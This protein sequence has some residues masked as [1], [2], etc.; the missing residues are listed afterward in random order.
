MITIR[1]VD[2]PRDYR[3]FFNFP[4]TLYRND[5]NWVPP[6]LSS[7]REILEAKHNPAW[8]YLEGDYF[9]A[10]RG[11]ELVGT[12]AAFVNKRHNE[13]HGEQVGWFGA[14]ETI[15]DEGV[16]HS[17]IN[18]AADWVRAKGLPILR[19][20]QTLT[21]HELVGCLVDGFIPPA[22]LMPY[23]PPYYPHL[24]ESAG[25]QKVTDMYS[26][27]L[28]QD[29]ARANGLYDRLARISQSIM[30]RNKITVEVADPKNLKAAFANIKEIYNTAW[31]KNWGFVPLTPRELDAIVDGLGMV[32]DARMLY[33]GYVEGQLAGFILAVPDLNMAIKH[34]YPRPGEWE[35]F[36]LLKVLWH[37][38]VR[39]K[40][41]TVRVPLMGV[42]AEHRSRGVDA[43]LY[44]H[45]LQA[46]TNCGYHKSD[47]GW[48]LEKNETMV[49]I[50]QNFGSRIYKTHR[51]YE[52]AV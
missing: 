29:E 12:V 36:T 11:D 17:L 47:S 37:W 21:T 24:I 27:Y 9:C 50:A 20:P 30:K 1:K 26:F 28:D 52:K 46:I 44:S 42:K 2:N 23:N 49:S 31:D 32:V 22:L 41:D 6:L 35:L 48:I 10:W 34:A 5:P 33:F 15:N 18:T 3:A 25:L 38:K 13:F 14:F 7:R 4:W 43:V 51:L 45:I 39:S 8:E 19:G 40:I 16:A